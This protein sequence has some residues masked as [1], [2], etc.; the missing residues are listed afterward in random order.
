MRVN[1]SHAVEPTQAAIARAAKAS[2][3]ST[4]FAGA[5]A[6]A[7]A[8]ASTAPAAAS[9]STP[10]SA[11]AAAKPTYPGAPKGEQYAPV[12]GRDDCVEIVGGP[13]NGMFVNTSG[14]SR[15]GEAFIVVK[16]ADR[17]LHVYGTGKERD[18][19]TVHHADAASKPGK[20]DRPKGPHEDPQPR[21]PVPKGEAYED[22]AGRT[23]YDEITK[24][25]RNG[26]FLNMSGN[27]RDGRAFVLVER[28]G[29]DLHIYGTG[30]HRQ[31]IT[32]PDLE[33]PMAPTAPAA[34]PAQPQPGT[35]QV[36]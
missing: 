13:R 2:V 29:H 12:D 26:M 30:R 28:Q 20:P 32:V 5:L 31:V 9:P 35:S 11:P 6:K 17:D 4:P 21:G 7:S 16:R 23:D 33:A 3:A 1:P 10:A 22:V 8:K 25:A 24:G 14:N 18:V 19:V 34:T 36:G 15:D 27:A